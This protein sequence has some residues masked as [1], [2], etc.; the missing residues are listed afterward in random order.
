M[1]IFSNDNGVGLRNKGDEKMYE[2]QQIEYDYLTEP[3][4]IYDKKNRQC[5]D[6]DYCKSVK[7][8]NLRTVFLCTDCDNDTYLSEVSLRDYCYDES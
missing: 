3:E 2:T 7:N 1:V 5:V 8:S 6:C 4:F